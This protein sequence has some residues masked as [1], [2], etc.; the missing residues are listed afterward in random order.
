MKQLFFPALKQNVTRDF[1]KKY[2][3][4]EKDKKSISYKF[5]CR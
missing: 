5:Y 3:Q 2:F 1:S 4:G